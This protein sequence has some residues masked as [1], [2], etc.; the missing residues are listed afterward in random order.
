M[1]PA[2]TGHSTPFT[3]T[4]NDRKPADT[5]KEVS[6]AIDSAVKNT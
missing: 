5:G 3:T 4:M 6:Y 2:C 1:N